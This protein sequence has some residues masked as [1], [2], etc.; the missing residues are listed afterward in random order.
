MRVPVLTYHSIN[1]SGDDHARN[2]HVALAADLALLRREGWRV[3]PLH[4]VVATLLGERADD[5]DRCVALTFDDGSW[6]DWVDL[7]HPTWGMQRSFANILRE[8]GP[9][10][11]ATSFVIV[12]PEARAV[13]D[14]T[15]MI[16][17]G[18]WTDS[19]WADAAGEGLIAIES[20]SW[21]HNH[22]TLPAT[23]Q[24][25]GRTGTFRS[26][27]THDVADAEIRQAADWLDAHLPGQRT[28]LLAYPY[29][30]SNAYLV[31]DYLPR[32]AHE[33][34][35]RAAFATGPAPVTSSSDRWVLPRYVCGRDW[36]SPE[37]L[38]AVLREAG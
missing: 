14:R 18:W 3:V 20:H 17:R 19:W 28:S 9:G 6:F 23:A 34:R 1:I 10:L 2:D 25:D 22:E 21:D 35:V 4:D 12:S 7:E 11:H 32:H 37:G 29:G 16:G 38:S 33:H 36:S 26:V 13:L 31:G 15:C 5:L 30:E 8:A 24:R 27:D